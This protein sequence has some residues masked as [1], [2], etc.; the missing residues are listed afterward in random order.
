MIWRITILHMAYSKR[1]MMMYVTGVSIVL[2]KHCN[3]EHYEII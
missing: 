2:L 1:K 3:G